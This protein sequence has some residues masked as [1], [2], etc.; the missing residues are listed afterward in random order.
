MSRVIETRFLMFLVTAFFFFLFLEKQNY[1]S[2]LHPYMYIL[3]FLTTIYSI[4]EK[5]TPSLW[6]VDQ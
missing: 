6:N 3:H 1:S 2:L 4:L 5:F